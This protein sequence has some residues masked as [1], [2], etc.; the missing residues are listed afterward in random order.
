MDEYITIAE[1]AKKIGVSK[2][3]LRRW[4]KSGKFNSIRHPI[5][6]YRVYKTEFVNS[7]VNEI[8]FEYNTEQVKTSKY[9]EPY[10]QT[11]YG[12]LYNLDAPSFLKT[13]ES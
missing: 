12:K 5:N 13:I 10:F 1:A 6:N 11:N 7:L 4:D 3:T 8:Q 9:I 2:E